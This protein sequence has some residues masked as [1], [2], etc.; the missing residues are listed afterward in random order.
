MA[1]EQE[2]ATIATE[3][4]APAP[5]AVVTPAPA[6]AR[7][8]KSEV[9][10]EHPASHYLVVED[11]EHPTTW[12]LRVRSVD[13]ALDHR[14]MGA[15][16]AALHEGYRGNRYEGPD[17]AGALRKL[18]ELYE[19]E[20]MPLPGAA[21]AIEFHLAFA[22]VFGETGDA[23]T[24]FVEGYANT[25][26]VDRVGDRIFPEAFRRGLTAY[27]RNPVVLLHHDPQRPIGK[28]L[29]AAVDEIGLYVRVAIDRTLEWG[30]EA[31]KMIERGI[32]NAFSVRAVDD[33]A[34]GWVDASGVRN[35]SNWDLREISAVTV[36]AH[37]QALFSI[38]KALRDG[39]D[40]IS[41]V[42]AETAPNR[43][44]VKTMA[45]EKDTAAPLA[46]APHVDEEALIAKA[47]MRMEAKAKAE[48]DQ[49]AAQAQERATWEAD[50]RK[51]WDAEQETARQAA[52]AKQQPPF[53]VVDLDDVKVTGPSAGQMRQLGRLIVSSKFD[54]LGDVDLIMRYYLQSQA[55]RVGAAERPSERFQRA[56]MVRAA[57]FMQ[58]E[59]TL[60]V[61]DPYPGARPRTAKSPAFDPLVVR[62]YVAAD[63]D[64]GDVLS[65]DG[66]VLARGVRFDDN[67]SAR[68]V[69]QLLE[70]G[71]KADELIYST[72]SGYGDQWVPTLMS[73][74]LWR[75]VRLN[76]VVLPVFDQFDM[77]SQPYDYPAE[78]TDPTFYKVAESTDETQLVIGGTAFSDSKVGTAKTTFSAGKLGALSYW[79]EEMAED[80]IVAVEPMLRNQFGISLA[81]A[82]DKLLLHGDETGGAA[83]TGNIS[84]Y[85]SNV[86]TT[87]DILVIDG[88]RHEPLV[89]TTSDK[90]DGGALTIDDIASTRALMGAAGI[91]GADPSQLALICD[92]PTGLKFSDLAEVL[93]V[94]KFGPQA[95]VLTGQV[96]A[97]KG[98]PL[99]VSQDFG[100]TDTSGY[101]NG[102]A[103]SNTK[104]SFLCV[105]RLGIKVGWRRRPRV[106]VGQ[107][108]FSDAWYIM[109]TARFDVGFFAAGMVGLSYNITV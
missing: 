108:P 48:R 89:T 59:D 75:Q 100:L 93:T 106:Y 72:Q 70:I 39:V 65:A 25:G 37:Q 95:T 83:E 44:G 28:V 69:A 90:R 97:I 51:K 86:G 42:E 66:K 73:A 96:G 38:A 27:M 14:L 57:K 82:I 92:V 94:D 67:V 98:L 16:W 1:D 109:A 74:M 63:E 35:I 101:V 81:H 56:V 79:S 80:S 32:L 2:Q 53:P 8:T 40:V 34:E 7:V 87:R 50:L 10:G 15:A 6:K 5:P 17:T 52:A 11:P 78:S 29:S 3:V 84:Y 41:G 47:I 12:H 68:G 45:D 33:L 31:A 23:D 24:L 9:D 58:A 4:A 85:G 103:S 30:R 104:G 71:A 13:G 26:V 102:T 18:K 54:R 61:W 60:P 46:N 36:P 91:Y 76:T 22:K 49:A 88:L 105:N 21:K 64:R 62:P 20:G 77:P 19:R 43:R 55:A 107:I 99:V